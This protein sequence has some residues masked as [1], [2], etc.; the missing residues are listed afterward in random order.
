VGNVDPGEL[1]VEDLKAIR[2]AFIV[3]GRKMI[4]NAVERDWHCECCKDSGKVKRNCKLVVKMVN[5]GV[6]Y[7]RRAASDLANFAQDAN[8]SE[9]M[10][11]EERVILGMFLDY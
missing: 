4:N 11:E 8:W 3:H 10:K 9:V 2:T 5:R 1:S 7:L 6:W